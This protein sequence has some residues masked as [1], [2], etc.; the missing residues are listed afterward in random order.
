MD[1]HELLVR[2]HA[3]HGEGSDPFANTA[4]D[5]PLRSCENLVAGVIRFVGRSRY[6]MLQTTVDTHPGHDSLHLGLRSMDQRGAL[7]KGVTLLRDLRGGV[8]LRHLAE[9]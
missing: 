6:G 1:V 8:D 3:K 7:T 9:Y 5:D 2:G 4:V